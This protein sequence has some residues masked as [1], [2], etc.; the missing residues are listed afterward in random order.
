MGLLLRKESHQIGVPGRKPKFCL[1][2]FPHFVQ[3]ILGCK[4]VTRTAGASPHSPAE[5][6]RRQNSEPDITIEQDAHEAGRE[7]PLRSSGFCMATRQRSPMR[8]LKCFLSKKDIDKRAWPAHP[9]T[10]GFPQ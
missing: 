2:L 10:A 7:F 3:N 1:Q 9:A 5:S 8:G 6:I 4:K